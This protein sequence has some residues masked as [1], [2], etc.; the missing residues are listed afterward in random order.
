MGRIILSK[1]ST[2]PPNDLEKNA[3]AVYTEKWVSRIGELQYALYAEKKQALLVVLQG[4]DG[5]GKDSTIKN[6]FNGCSALGVRVYQFRKPTE[7]ESAHDFLWRVHKVTPEKGII[8]IFVRSH[9]EDVL[10]QRVH[11]WISEERAKKR[12][13][14]IN[15]FEEL[16]K[17]DNKTVVLKFYMHISREQQKIE[18]QQRINDRM[19]QWKHDASDW[20]ESKLWEKYMACYED[21]INQSSIPWHIVPV[22]K[23]WYRD[24][25]IAKI[26]CESLENMDPKLPTFKTG[27]QR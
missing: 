11:K 24:Y 6:V 5:S 27:V 7:I 20:E 19:K 17:F 13:E 3:A 2:L 21:A 14:A 26:T 8:Q 10:V 9:Y 16:L 4:M 25:V 15:A 22:D 23:R 1:I 18:L 12:I